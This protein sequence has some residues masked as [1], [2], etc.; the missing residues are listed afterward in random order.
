MKIKIGDTIL[1]CNLEATLKVQ[2]PPKDKIQIHYTKN[3]IKVIMNNSFAKIYKHDLGYM[4]N[5]ISLRKKVEYKKRVLDSFLY[6]YSVMHLE[7]K[8]WTLY[9]FKNID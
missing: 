4:Y 8:R 1:E 2:M 3:K 7:P 6:Q 9:N 5:N